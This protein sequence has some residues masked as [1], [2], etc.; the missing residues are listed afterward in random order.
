ML[1][2]L[3]IDDEVYQ[4][5]F[6]EAIYNYLKAE[7]VIIKSS[8]IPPLNTVPHGAQIESLLGKSKTG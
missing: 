6:I 2:P 5:K 7:P 8:C 1:L 4:L 3:L